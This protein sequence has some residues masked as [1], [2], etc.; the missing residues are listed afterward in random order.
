MLSW[1]FTYST[2]Y[3]MLL[4]K[5]TTHTSFIPGGTFNLTKLYIPKE[6]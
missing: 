6:A 4:R 3:I 2:C 1:Y 5:I